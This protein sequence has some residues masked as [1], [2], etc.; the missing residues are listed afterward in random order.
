MSDSY[1][2]DK[3]T[4]T[5]TDFSR[6]GWHDC[7][8]HAIA[9]VPDQFEFVLDIDY[10][11][12]WVNPQPGEA[13]FKFWVAPATLVFEN[14]C[15]IVFDLKTDGGVEVESLIR[16]APQRPHNAEHIGREL[17]WR[18]IFECQEGS[19]SFQ[20]V[21]YK[22]YVRAMPQLTQHQILTLETRGGITFLRGRADGEIAT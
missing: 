10:I 12:Q 3:W 6:M 9:F 20:S 19:I 1:E 2:L 8:I 13:C 16:E 22:Q 4:W 21:G 17:E 5:E 14:V 11:F 7:H 18:W 15:N